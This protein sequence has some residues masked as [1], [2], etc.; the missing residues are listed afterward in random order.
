MPSSAASVHAVR[1]RL[2]TS[3][4]KPSCAPPPSVVRI[5]DS[6]ARA[7]SAAD[8]SATVTGDG[9]PPSNLRAQAR[10]RDNSAWQISLEHASGA[11]PVYPSLLKH[12]QTLTKQQQCISERCDFSQPF[13]PANHPLLINFLL[14]YSS[15]T[16]SPSPVSP[17]LTVLTTRGAANVSSSSLRCFSADTTA[18]S[19]S[20]T[21]LLLSSAPPCPCTPPTLLRATGAATVGCCASAAATATVS[22]RRLIGCC[23]KSD[24]AAGVKEQPPRNRA[25]R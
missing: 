13:F 2:L 23:N 5:R 4:S 25:S 8:R 10:R 16:H 24:A 22:S 7:S 11:R 3:I 17:H 14:P 1:L 20:P 21:A 15:P 12:K 9:P 19:C 6:S 18:A